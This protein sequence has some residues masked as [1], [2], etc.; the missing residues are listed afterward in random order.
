M[1]GTWAQVLKNPVVFL[2]DLAC[3]V[4][5]QVFS[6]ASLSI[7]QSFGWRE[8]AFVEAFLSSPIN[9]SKLPTFSAITRDTMRHQENLKHSPP[10]VLGPEIPTWPI[11]PSLRLSVFS[12][13]CFF[14]YTYI[15]IQNF[16]LYVRVRNRENYIHSIFLKSVPCHFTQLT[17][18]LCTRT[19][20]DFLIFTAT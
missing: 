7:S 1:P 2:W 20:K 6:S 14:V 15:N 3:V 9:I 16:Y 8:Q 13:F 4:T 11:V 17:R 19:S 10:R 5:P 12:S 18:T